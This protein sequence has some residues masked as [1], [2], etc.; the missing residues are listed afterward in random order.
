MRAGL[1]NRQP[2]TCEFLLAIS[3]WEVVRAVGSDGHGKLEAEV[4]A[5]RALQPLPLFA[6]IFAL[7]EQ[8]GVLAC[9]S[10]RRSPVQIRSRAPFGVRWQSH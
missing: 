1:P 2:C 5:G 4:D 8:P 7:V 6:L 10:R 9:L 3:D